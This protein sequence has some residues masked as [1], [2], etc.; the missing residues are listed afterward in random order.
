MTWITDIVGM[1]VIKKRTVIGF[2][3][4]YFIKLTTGYD[5][6]CLEVIYFLD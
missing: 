5:L 3:N 6:C 1:M 4:G 2:G